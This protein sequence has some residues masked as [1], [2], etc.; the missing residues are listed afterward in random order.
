[1]QEAV[2]LRLLAAAVAEAGRRHALADAALL[3]EVLLQTGDVLAHHVVELVDQG[4]SDVGYRLVAALVDVAQVVLRVVVADAVGLHLTGAC[5]VG[6]PLRQAAH[7][8]V[9]L[10]IDQQLLH[11][12]TRHIRQLQLRLRRS[13]AGG[14]SLGNVLLARA[15]CLH[16]LVDGAVALREEPPGEVEGD[17]VDAL[18]LLIDEQ[19]AIVTLPGQECG[20][21]LHSGLLVLL[22]L[23]QSGLNS[24]LRGPPEIGVP[25]GANRRAV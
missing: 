4:D 10:V 13:G 21:R 22:R 2:Y 8:Q 20:W 9:V 14:T 1:M 6:R 19:I 23:F 24:C 25:C 5:V 12:G 3:G 16:H 18:G 17:V 7:A 11:A 15:G